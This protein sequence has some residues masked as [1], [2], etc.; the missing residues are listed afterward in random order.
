MQKLY[1]VENR[2]AKTAL[3]FFLD[4]A[5]QLG[6]TGKILSD[7]N[8]NFESE[9]FQISLF[10]LE[11]K[12]IWTSGY[13]ARTN[14][15]AQLS[16]ITIKSNLTRYLVK[17]NGKD[18]WALLLNFFSLDE[19]AARLNRIYEHARHKASMKVYYYRKRIDG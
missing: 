14:G 18:E 4:Y 8:L 3:E 2:T 19:M 9:L 16:N 10:A 17:K 6:I 12:T 13:R 15:L 11:I 7:M 5:L 1:T